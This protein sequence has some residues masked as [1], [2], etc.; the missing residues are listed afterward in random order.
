M[1]HAAIIPN[2]FQLNEDFDNIIVPSQTSRKRRNLR[3]G[4]TIAQK[5]SKSTCP[6]QPQHQQIHHQQQPGLSDQ[7]LSTPKTVIESEYTL[8]PLR[9]YEH[10]LIQGKG[11]SPCSPHHTAFALQDFDQTC[12]KL[13]DVYYIVR[14][15]HITCCDGNT[16]VYACQCERARETLVFAIEQPYN[17]SVQEIKDLDQHA[18]HVE[19][20]HIKA[21]RELLRSTITTDD[22]N[23][24][25]VNDV[26]DHQYC[27]SNDHV[28]LYPLLSTEHA[29]CVHI[30]T[31]NSSNESYAIV[32]LN[33]QGGHSLACSVC[34][35]APCPHTDAIK[36]SGHSLA[37]VLKEL[38]SSKPSFRAR[39]VPYPIS[40]KKKD[41]SMS[42][43][44][45]KYENSF[46]PDTSGICV[47]GSPWGELTDGLD[48]MMFTATTS[49]S[50]RGMQILRDAS[51]NNAVFFL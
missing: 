16:W 28:E 10:L 6:K 27:K 7:E 29:V 41:F 42:S 25:S 18:N 12:N 32:S 26:S 49:S 44:Q 2:R 20:L 24:H 15:R 30:S 43:F 38:L 9:Q 21:C 11:L 22:Y 40:K 35:K 37:E 46:A 4:D 45:G 14:R 19:C 17:G 36:C 1:N 8:T 23:S 50:V 33:F 13:K 48:S 47:C 34:K 39:Y 51:Q 5:A 3:K 31:G